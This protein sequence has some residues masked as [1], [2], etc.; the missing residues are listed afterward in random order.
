MLCQSYTM[1]W[2][3]KVSQRMTLWHATL[4]EFAES[5]NASGAIKPSQVLETENPNE[6]FSGWQFTESQGKYGDGVYLAT[7]A[8]EAM[9]YANIRLSDQRDNL[10]TDNEMDLYD[11]N[12]EY[13]ALYRVTITDPTKLVQLGDSE[14]KYQGIITNQPNAQASFQFIRFV[15]RTRDAEKWRNKLEETQMRDDD[16]FDSFAP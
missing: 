13:L 7:T 6:Q 15:P 2:F 8:E 16:D 1:N 12:L 4:P 3:Q 14:Y 11:D 5:I 10:D 9:Y